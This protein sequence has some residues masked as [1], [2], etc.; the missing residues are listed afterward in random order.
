MYFELRVC[1]LA[2]RQQSPVGR[3]VVM[4]DI[5]E[6]K[7]AELEHEQLVREQSAHAAAERARRHLRLLAN[8]SLQLA[9]S[10]DYETTLQTVARLAVPD[11]ADWCLVTTQLTDDPD[12]ILVIRTPAGGLVPVYKGRTS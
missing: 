6:R 12:P 8:S 10:L 7:R 1:S 2:D 4:H 9:K 3:L 5:T 11:L